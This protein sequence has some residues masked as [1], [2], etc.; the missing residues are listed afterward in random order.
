V[1][2]GSWEAAVA[3]LHAEGFEVAHAACDN[4][5]HQVVAFAPKDSNRLACSGC[6]GRLKIT[7]MITEED[8]RGT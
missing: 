8:V 2:F 1:Q 4:G 6:G 7:A 3:Y 5:G